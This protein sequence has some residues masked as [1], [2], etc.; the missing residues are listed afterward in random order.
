MKTRF[1]FSVLAL[2]WGVCALSTAT[3][4][5]KTITAAEF[6]STDGGEVP[7]YFDRQRKALAINAAVEDYREKFARA[8]VSFDGPTGTYTVTIHAMRETDGDCTYRLFV[9]DKLIGQVANDE[10]AIDYAKQAH[11]FEGVKITHGA[12]LSVE[13]NAVTNGKIPEGDGTAFARGRWTAITA[14]QQ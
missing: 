2:L 8:S 13:S 5:T 6:A 4:E 9:N 12:T 11:V 7:Y 1:S 3:A 10:T 14:E